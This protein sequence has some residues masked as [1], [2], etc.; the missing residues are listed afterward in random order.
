MVHEFPPIFI[1]V[2]IIKMS[3]PF[4]WGMKSP[5]TPTNFI[6]M[7]P[8]ESDKVFEN[9]VPVQMQL[10]ATEERKHFLRLSV[11]LISSGMSSTSFRKV[12]YKI[13]HVP[14]QKHHP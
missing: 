6:G 9:M 14:K 10:S 7:R 3:K 1:L 2:E 5:I 12:F 13:F 4:T 11:E 8:S